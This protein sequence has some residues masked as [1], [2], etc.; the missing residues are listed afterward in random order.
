M[1]RYLYYHYNSQGTIIF[2]YLEDDCQICSR[3][4]GCSL[5]KA[6]QKFRQE[7]NLQHKHVAIH[8]L[9]EAEQ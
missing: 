5:Q 9:Y 2:H 8:R 7:Y 3:Y 1:K 6:I 4:N